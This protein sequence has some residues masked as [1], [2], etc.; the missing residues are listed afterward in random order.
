M[1]NVITNC[2]K[3]SPHPKESDLKTISE[4]PESR[5]CICTECGSYWIDGAD[6]W[7][8]LLPSQEEG[9]KGDGY[10]LAV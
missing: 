10:K 2:L 7:D 9:E 3:C 5:I 6:G 4:V 1:M 8:L